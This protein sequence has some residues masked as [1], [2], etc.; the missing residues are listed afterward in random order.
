MAAAEM[1][2]AKAPSRTPVGTGSPPTGTAETVTCRRIVG[3]RKTP[4][5]GHPA[6]KF[7]TGSA[8]RKPKSAI[9]RRATLLAGT[10]RRDT[11]REGRSRPASRHLWRYLLLGARG[12]L[13]RARAHRERGR[14][15]SIPAVQAARWSP[16]QNSLRRRG[17]MA[18]E[19]RRAGP[20]FVHWGLRAIDDARAIA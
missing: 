10:P 17:P 5:A 1:G 6:P 19:G 15:Y 4:L 16:P 2:S 7:G 18:P 13:Y 8:W 11:L 14:S 20:L 3:E 9:E 12:K